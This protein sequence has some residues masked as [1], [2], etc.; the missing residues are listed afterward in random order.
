M[1]VSEAPIFEQVSQLLEELTTFNRL[2]SRGTVRLALKQAG[3]SPRAVGHH[4]ML[5]VLER[6][7]PEALAARG[8]AHASEVCTRLAARLTALD[9]DDAA[10]ASE[11]PEEVFRRF[12]RT[13]R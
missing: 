1:A 6:V 2:E 3:F 7:L 12:R 4:E 11:S 8:V 9:G 13:G 5:V 10:D